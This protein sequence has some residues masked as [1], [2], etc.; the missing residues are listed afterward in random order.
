MSKLPGLSEI[1]WSLTPRHDTQ[2]ESDEE[3]AGPTEDTPTPCKSKDGETDI[4]SKQEESRFLPGEGAKLDLMGLLF[5]S[6]RREGIDLDI[7]PDT[8]LLIPVAVFRNVGFL[9]RLQ[10]CSLQVRDRWTYHRV[11]V[12][13]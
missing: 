6:E 12:F 2:A 10:Q 3:P 8:V 1:R 7:F 13:W 11:L 4:L 5:D 9:I